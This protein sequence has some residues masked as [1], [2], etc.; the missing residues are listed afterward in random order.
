MNNQNLNLNWLIYEIS[1]N[2]FKWYKCTKPY[3]Y[4]TSLLMH[5]EWKL[6]LLCMFQK[7]MYMVKKK[8]RKTPN[9]NLY[10]T[11]I[12]QLWKFEERY[13]N[14]ENFK[15]YR[16][17]YPWGW[18][19]DLINHH[20]TM[21]FISLLWDQSMCNFVIYLNSNC[22]MFTFIVIS[23]TL[24][25]NLYLL[26]LRTLVYL[27]DWHERY[28]DIV[29]ETNWFE[30]ISKFFK[31]WPRNDAERTNNS[32]QNLDYNSCSEICKTY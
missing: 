12:A 29:K 7:Y 23:F 24:P 8:M 22:F 26:H 25:L 27:F 4:V 10:L 14:V 19:S 15:V 30:N 2:N 21:L 6:G 31:I 17:R 13:R 20:N 28:S 9:Y 32:L 1:L 11:E 3:A 18:D 5:C 16:Y